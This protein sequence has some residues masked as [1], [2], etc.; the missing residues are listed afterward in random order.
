MTMG[1]Q[2]SGFIINMY[3]AAWQLQ[4]KRFAE[5]LEKLT[6]EQ[7]DAETAPGRN[8]GTYLLGH[9]VAVSDAMLKLMGFREKIYPD[10]EEVFIKSPDKS[11]K[12]RPSAQDLRKYYHEVTNELNGFIDTLS[13]DEWLD[14]HMAV[15]EEDFAKEPMRNKLNI[16]ISRTTHM[17]NH[18]GQMIYLQK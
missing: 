11:S 18:Q 8:T 13:P 14:R 9:M 4:N 6:D 2:Q 3:I 7:L 10:L 15:S 1:T 17:A 5:L 16:L 12:A